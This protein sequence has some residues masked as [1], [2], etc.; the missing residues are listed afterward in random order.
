MHRPMGCFMCMCTTNSLLQGVRAFVLFAMLNQRHKSDTIP[1]ALVMYVMKYITE[2]KHGYLLPPL[3]FPIL[4][5]RWWLQCK[6]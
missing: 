6:C 5:N 1:D 3:L 4:V 2:M